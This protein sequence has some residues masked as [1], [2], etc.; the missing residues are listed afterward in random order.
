M[1]GNHDQNILDDFSRIF[2][3]KE[4]QR[5]NEGQRPNANV[6]AKFWIFSI[7]QMPVS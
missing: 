2:L 4:K 3:N 6:F 7:I 5:E 1:G